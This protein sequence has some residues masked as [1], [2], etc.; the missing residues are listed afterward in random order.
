MADF[1]AEFFYTQDSKA[2][3]LDTIV[4]NHIQQKE[5]VVV[6]WQLFEQNFSVLTNSKSTFFQEKGVINMVDINASLFCFI[7]SWTDA[8][9][10]LVFWRL[11]H[12]LDFLKVLLILLTYLIT[13]LRCSNFHMKFVVVIPIF[14]SK[15][16]VSI[17]WSISKKIIPWKFFHFV[18]A[19]GSASSQGFHARTRLCRIIFF[20]LFEN[21]DML[22]DGIVFF[23]RF[24]LRG[25]DH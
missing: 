13:I 17:I 19:F 15:R 11:Y 8:K 14:Q 24:S 16:F 21:D 4:H 5:E 12:A 3:F 6:N 7:W 23:A 2:D 1:R 9:E 22:L 25:D 10:K 18:S 20:F